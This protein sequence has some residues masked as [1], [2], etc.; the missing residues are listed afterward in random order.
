MNIWGHYSAHSTPQE[1]HRWVTQGTSEIIGNAATKGHAQNP[2]HYDDKLG[3]HV[4]DG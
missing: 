4:C 2:G 3:S 1:L